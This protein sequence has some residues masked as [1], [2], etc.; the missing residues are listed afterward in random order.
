MNTLQLN[1]R[2]LFGR[3]EGAPA[4][5]ALTT[6]QII[7]YVGIAVSAAS[8]AY[9]ITAQRAQA[10]YQGQVEEENRKLAMLAADD[11]I[12]R[13]DVEEQAARMR[14]RQ[15]ISLQDA[16]FA[17]SGVEVGSGS[18]LD[19]TMDTAQFGELDALTIR[20]NA[21]R[22][23]WGYL[24]DATAASR[25]SSLTRASART[26]SGATLLTGGSQALSI[27]QSGLS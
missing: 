17:A 11:A 4:G 13:G 9:A 21:Q 15:L 23:A 26:Q 8:T 12:Q 19:V 16:K 22:E 1:G 18:A 24:S 2:S 7:S 14:T 10:R 25:R 5:A 27:Y 6:A 20:N 3:M